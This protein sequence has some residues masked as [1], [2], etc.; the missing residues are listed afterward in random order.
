[1]ATQKPEYYKAFP[2]LDPDKAAAHDS[3]TKTCSI[4]I[5]KN[6]IISPKGFKK[7][8]IMNNEEVTA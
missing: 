4:R 6:K 5:S 3:T 2:E 7:Y 1:M 8:I